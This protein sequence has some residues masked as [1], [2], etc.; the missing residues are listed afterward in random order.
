M[1]GRQCALSQ[2]VPPLTTSPLLTEPIAALFREPF[3]A[4]PGGQR[5]KGTCR[6][7]LDSTPPTSTKMDLLH[8]LSLNLES[9]PED[10]QNSLCDLEIRGD[11]TLSRV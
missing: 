5:E 8:L 4:Q 10:T 9:G 6:R 3:A 11:L 7:Q 1:T 2:Q